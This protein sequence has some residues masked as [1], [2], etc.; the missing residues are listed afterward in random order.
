VLATIIRASSWNTNPVLS[1]GIP[2]RGLIM[3]TSGVV[4]SRPS[5]PP[6][7]RVMFPIV[8]S[9]RPGKTAMRP[10]P[11]RVPMWIP[12]ARSRIGVSAGRSSVPS[13]HSQHK[14]TDDGC[15]V[16][17]IASVTNRHPVADAR[18]H[19]CSPGSQYPTAGRPPSHG[20]TL[21]TLAPC[22]ML[23]RTSHRPQTSWVS[24]P[25]AVASPRRRHRPSPAVPRF[26]TLTRTQLAA[27]GA[28]GQAV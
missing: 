15:P 9:T 27:S 25:D 3:T 20:V 19:E 5:P 14:C 28:A 4:W 10:P 16:P 13:F 22:S 26:V 24:P 12:I 7:R 23:F 1:Q 21:T 17:N 2:I 11:Y 18:R 6:T 8:T